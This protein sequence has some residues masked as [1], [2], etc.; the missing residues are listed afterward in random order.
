M[1]AFGV[2]LDAIIVRALLV[3]ALA[4]DM[5]RIVCA[6]TVKHRNNKITLI[7]LFLAV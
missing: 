4:Y 1:V 7:L 2:L 3:P 5:G 6:T